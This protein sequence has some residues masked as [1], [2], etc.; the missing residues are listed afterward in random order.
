MDFVELDEP[1]GRSD[2]GRIQNEKDAENSL[3]VQKMNRQINFIAM[4][5]IC[6]LSAYDEDLGDHGYLKNRGRF[7]MLQG[8]VSPSGADKECVSKKNVSGQI[9]YTRKSFVF[10]KR[11]WCKYNRTEKYCIDE[12]WA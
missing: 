5:I 10:N 12:I 1:K 2:E 11:C 8:S 7:G 6:N 4:Q 3:A 9:T